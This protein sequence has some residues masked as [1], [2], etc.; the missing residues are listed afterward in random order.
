MPEFAERAD[1]HEK[2]KLERLGP[3]MDAALAR[4]DPPREA[5]DV[6]IQPSASV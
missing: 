2:A 3:A 5:P 1:G 6:V 4:R